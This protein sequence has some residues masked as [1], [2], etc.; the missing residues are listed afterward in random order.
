MLSELFRLGLVVTPHFRMSS[1]EFQSLY[2]G[3]KTS[4]GGSNAENVFDIDRREPYRSILT[5][6][7]EEIKR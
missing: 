3:L 2:H 1:Q 4:F 7:I 5:C 6:F